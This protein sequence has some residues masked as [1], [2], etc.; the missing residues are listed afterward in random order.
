[1]LQSSQHDNS[2]LDSR[3]SPPRHFPPS[4]THVVV[5]PMGSFLLPCPL[6][7]LGEAVAAALHF[8]NK[9]PKTKQHKYGQFTPKGDSDYIGS[10][11]AVTRHAISVVPMAPKN[12][13]QKPNARF[14]ICECLTEPERTNN[15][16]T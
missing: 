9:Y 5:G 13:Q 6:E 12:K 1:M 11:N 15:T 4:A 8:S 16:S 14:T 3:F 10:H 2:C 7:W